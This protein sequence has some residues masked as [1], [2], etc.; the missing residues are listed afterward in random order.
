[1][2]CQIARHYYHYNLLT[3]CEF[4]AQLHVKSGVGVATEEN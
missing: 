4:I 1:M 3:H 2:Q